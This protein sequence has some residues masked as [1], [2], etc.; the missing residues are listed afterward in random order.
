MIQRRYITKLEWSN[1]AVIGVAS[2]GHCDTCP[3]ELPTV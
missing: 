3:P 2:Y 1:C